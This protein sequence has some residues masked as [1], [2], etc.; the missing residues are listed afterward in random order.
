V[1]A[2]NAAARAGTLGETVQAILED[3]KPEAVYFAAQDGKRTTIMIV[4]MADASDLP[5][6]AE[7]WFL[8]FDASIDIIPLM[9]PEDLA[10]AGPAIENAV[11]KFG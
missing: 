2:G 1:A 9:L 6:I 10:K 3:I 11:K 7:P 5:A 8:A 4:D